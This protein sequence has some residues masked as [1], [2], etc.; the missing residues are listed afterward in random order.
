[1]A[2]KPTHMRRADLALMMK[3]DWKIYRGDNLLDRRITLKIFLGYEYVDVTELF[4]MG[5]NERLL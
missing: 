4:R 3:F 2:V 1:M 5:Y